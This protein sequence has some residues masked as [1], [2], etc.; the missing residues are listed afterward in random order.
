[1]H[2]CSRDSQPPHHDFKIG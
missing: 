1:M 2:T